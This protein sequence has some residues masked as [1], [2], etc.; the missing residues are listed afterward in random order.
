M[1]RIPSIMSNE[2][3]WFTPEILQS[4]WRRALQTGV[5]MKWF[6]LVLARTCVNQSWT[7]HHDG[8]KWQPIFFKMWREN[9]AAIFFIFTGFWSS[10]YLID[11]EI[12]SEFNGVIIIF[13]CWYLVWS[14]SVKN[15]GT[16]ITHIWQWCCQNCQRWQENFRKIDKKRH[17]NVKS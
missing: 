4:Y 6:T 10:L 8:T 13:S 14:L 11:I 1:I 15:T 17:K 5:W 2:H 12:Y 16:D 9:M 7:L 3:N